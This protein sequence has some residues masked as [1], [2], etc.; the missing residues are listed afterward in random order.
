[1]HRIDGA[2]NVNGQ[3]VSEDATTNRPPT[4][5]TADIMNALQEEIATFVEWCGIVLSKPDN[6]QLRKALVAKFA[7]LDSPIFTGQ[8]KGPT[9]AQFDNSTLLATTAH[10]KAAGFRHGASVAI[11]AAS[12]LDVTV[13]GKVV[14]LGGAGGYTVTLPNRAVVPDGE[15]ITFVCTATN[16][17]TV[18]RA[19]PD[20]VYPNN[21][22]ITSWSMA[23]G[24]T[25]TIES[26]AAVNGWALIGGS[27]QL[28]YG[29]MMGASRVPNGYTKLPNG[30]IIQWIGSSYSFSGSGQQTLDINFPIA[31]PNGVLSVIV[32]NS[33]NGTS[34]ND[35]VVQWNPIATTNAKFR[36]YCYS[37]I[38]AFTGFTAIAIGY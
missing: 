16:P 5:I 26:S 30:L 18:Q 21:A 22:S 19:G 33:E 1:M 32:G 23:N 8:A 4:E 9:P 36:V 6:E 27:S 7:Q 34:Q 28:V 11:N 3:W 31:F 12:V 29:G 20:V 24:D 37:A 35:G 38:A 25:A 10:V 17:V 13:V 14:V 15:S 2:G